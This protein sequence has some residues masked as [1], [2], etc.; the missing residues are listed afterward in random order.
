[1]PNRPSR[2]KTLI[3]CLASADHHRPRGAAERAAVTG[4][5]PVQ[6]T[7]AHAR[8]EVAQ[9]RAL[10][11]KVFRA[12]SKYEISDCK[13]TNCRTYHA[14]VVRYFST[15]K[16]FIGCRSQP[17]VPCVAHDP[18]YF[19]LVIASLPRKIRFLLT[20]SLVVHLRS[21]RFSQR[22]AFARSFHKRRIIWCNYQ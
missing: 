4:Y 20:C 7:A 5:A 1:V 6:T 8:S 9:A 14:G 17:V 22:A 19:I 21:L 16:I 15:G 13:S 2:K 10:W 18:E 3:G 12:Q 11:R